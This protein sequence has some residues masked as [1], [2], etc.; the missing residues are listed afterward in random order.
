MVRQILPFAVVALTVAFFRFDRWRKEAAIARLMT[1]EERA[2]WES[3]GA[4]FYTGPL[5]RLRRRVVLAYRSWR[6]S[7]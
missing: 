4:S 2:L 1:P 6:A 3:V 5:R 7:K